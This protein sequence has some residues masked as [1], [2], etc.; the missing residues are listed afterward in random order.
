MKKFSAGVPQICYEYSIEKIPS[1]SETKVF[2]GDVGL[3]GFG[4]G[5]IIRSDLDS[6]GEACREQAV[7]IPNSAGEKINR[8]PL[9]SSKDTHRNLS[10]KGLEVGSSFACYNEISVNYFLIESNNIKHGFYPWNQLRAKVGMKRAAKATGGTG[11]AHH[12]DIYASLGQYS[13]SLKFHP[14][15][16]HLNHLWISAFLRAEDSRGPIGAQKRI[17]HIAK[18]LYLDS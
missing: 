7:T 16:Q 18:D 3:D 12:R 14:L 17:V 11:S 4:D 9:T 2:A 13:F 1:G 6:G 10:G 15:L 5:D 8:D